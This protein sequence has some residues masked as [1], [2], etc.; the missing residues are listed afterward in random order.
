MN[1]RVK[2]ETKD[3]I[4]KIKTLQ[5]E[6]ERLKTSIKKGSEYYGSRFFSRRSS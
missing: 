4:S 1:T 3:E 2:V 6:I 5:K